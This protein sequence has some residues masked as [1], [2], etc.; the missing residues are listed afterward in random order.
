MGRPLKE[1]DPSEVE[2][3][4][5]Y[6]CTPTEIGAFF[7]VNETTIRKRFSEII[8]KGKESGKIRLRK[9]QIEVALKGNVSMLIWLGKQMLGQTDKQEIDHSGEIKTDN[10]L[11]V[12]VVQ[13]KSEVDNKPIEDNK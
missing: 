9:K 10:K 5:S 8:T 3:L 7:N 2:K 6:G 4:A 11:I 13:V 1:I 12:E